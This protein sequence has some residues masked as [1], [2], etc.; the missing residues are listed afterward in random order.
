MYL[1]SYRLC[2]NV[3]WLYRILYQWEVN[4]LFSFWG[5]EMQSKCWIGCFHQIMKQLQKIVFADNT[6]LA[7]LGAL[8]NSLH[9]VDGWAKNGRE[10]KIMTEIMATSFLIA[11]KKVTPK[12]KQP[13]KCKHPQKWRWP[14]K[15][16]I[17]KNEDNPNKYEVLL[18]A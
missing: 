8:A 9:K 12:W 17:P 14:K 1:I 15:G 16:D 7:A 10:K 13:Q 6:S 4:H 18:D 3:S 11:K 2:N 5:F